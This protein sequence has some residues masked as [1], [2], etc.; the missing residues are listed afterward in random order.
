MHD[1]SRADWTTTLDR[2]ELNHTQM[3]TLAGDDTTATIDILS[4]IIEI[5]S[6]VGLAFQLL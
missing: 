5:G 3:K 1:S 6:V 4:S 2:V